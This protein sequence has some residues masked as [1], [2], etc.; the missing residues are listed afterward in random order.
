M[1]N[2]FLFICAF[3]FFTNLSAQGYVDAI[4]IKKDGS[5]VQGLVESNFRTGTKKLK[6]KSSKKAKTETVQC[7]SLNYLVI[8]KD[9]V[10]LMLKYTNWFQPNFTLTKTVEKDKKFWLVVLNRCPAMEVMSHVSAIKSSKDE[11]T[12][13]Y[14]PDTKRYTFIQR[15]EER[16]PTVVAQLL[17][18]Y[19]PDRSSMF[20]DVNKDL[21]KNY[22]ESGGDDFDLPAELSLRFIY[23]VANTKCD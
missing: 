12:F 21:F 8:K 14:D 23:Q 16:I 4:L 6:F 2:I 9:G 18:P 17:D 11:L 22:L 1:K 5:E 10:E 15:A 20:N 13:V 19:N 7:E 3:G